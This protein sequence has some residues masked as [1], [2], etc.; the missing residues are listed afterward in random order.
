MEIPA[1]AKNRAFEALTRL[2]ALWVR[3][4]GAE[5]VYVWFM[6]YLS[7][8]FSSCL[9]IVKYFLDKESTGMRPDPITRTWIVPHG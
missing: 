2:W 1:A 9:Y 6:W 3:T 8:V 7:S 5:L 4:V